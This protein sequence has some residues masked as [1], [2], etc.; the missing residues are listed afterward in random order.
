MDY[1]NVGS[2]YR[3]RSGWAPEPKR[4]PIEIESAVH[5]LAP[6]HEISPLEYSSAYR[7]KSRSPSRWKRA[8]LGLS[9]AFVGGTFARPILERETRP[10]VER[11]IRDAR[12]V[13]PYLVDSLPTWTRSFLSE[14]D[15][16]AT[17]HFVLPRPRIHEL[18]REVVISP[19]DSR[20]AIP[21]EPVLADPV[22]PEPIERTNKHSRHVRSIRPAVSSR[23]LEVAS[24]NPTAAIPTPQEPPPAPDSIDAL[25]TRA[26]D[27]PLNNKQ[28]R[29]ARS[30]DAA[31]TLTQAQ[32][33]E[34]MRGLSSST[35]ACGAGLAKPTHIPLLVAVDRTGA[36]S[37]AH[38]T[39]ASFASREARCLEQAVKQAHFPES[40]G[41]KFRYRFA[42]YPTNLGV[43]MAMVVSPPERVSRPVPQAPVAIERKSDDVV[44]PKV[45]DKMRISN[46][47]LAGV[48]GRNTIEGK[49][50]VRRKTHR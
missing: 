10:R 6:S 3:P 18:V 50:I 38:A 47:P 48:N 39:G 46:D 5:W 14:D 26:L 36:V 19:P 44:V 27:E 31:A 41:M 15:Q 43:S 21:A 7:R 20:V 28:T 13:W 12:L 40:R 37:S 35:S 11:L 1:S 34:T 9:I 23:S 33:S 2:A 30:N 29:A 17:A 4:H 45:A 49:R 42:V 25:M 22:E 8:L 32:I 16:T 24:D